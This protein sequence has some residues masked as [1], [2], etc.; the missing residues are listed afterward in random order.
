MMTCSLSDSDTLAYSARP[1]SRA[2][3]LELLVSTPAGCR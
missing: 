2:A 1:L 3:M